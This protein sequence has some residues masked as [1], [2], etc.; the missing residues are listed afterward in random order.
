MT[1]DRQAVVE[2]IRKLRRLATSPNVHE[3]ARAREKAEALAT[4]CQ[5]RIEDEDNRDALVAA[6][7]LGSNRKW[8]AARLARM[9][10][11]IQEKQAISADLAARVAKDETKRRARKRL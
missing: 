10:A 1:T 7:V 5:I 9:W 2:R 8:T 3:A 6:I 11:T 4:Q